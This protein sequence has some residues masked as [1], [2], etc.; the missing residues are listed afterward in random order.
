MIFRSSKNKKKATILKNMLV[1]QKKQNYESEEV[2]E[3]QIAGKIK[4]KTKSVN[5]TYLR[6]GRDFF[7]L[8]WP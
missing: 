3:P 6:I 4:K 7:T 2:E 5:G 1:I 8:L